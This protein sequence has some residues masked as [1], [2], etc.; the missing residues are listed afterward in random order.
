[1]LESPKDEAC[2]ETGIVE[3]KPINA[4][5]KF[6]WKTLTHESGREHFLNDFVAP[7]EPS[8]RQ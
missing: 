5:G 7:S 4:I 3:L 8:G 1:M 2:D 6:I